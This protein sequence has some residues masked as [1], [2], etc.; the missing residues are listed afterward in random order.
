MKAPQ[1]YTF[2]GIGDRN[3]GQ[4]RKYAVYMPVH[5][6]NTFWSI[7]VASAEQDVLSG[8]I[9]FRNK[10]A[11]VIGA[12]FICG[13]VFSTLGAKAW[14]IVKEEEKRKQA[15]KKLQESEQIAEKFSTLF[16]AAPFAMALATTPDGVLYDVNQAWLD[17]AG[18]TRKEAVIGKT[19]VELELIREA[20]PRERILN[21]F[22]QHGSVRNAEIATCT[23]AGVQR[24]LLVNLDWVDIGG[25][26][27]ILSSMQDITAPTGR[28]AISASCRETPGRNA[29]L[30]ESRRGA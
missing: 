4:T 21:E 2:D 20:E 29:E 19:S 14:F 13:M 9:S 16:H 25:R 6:G 24:T 1:I 7:A 12:L 8:L 15:E 22:R 27:F 11:F 5:I 10:L 17:L 26:K 30:R 23:K 28:G 3:A 18:F